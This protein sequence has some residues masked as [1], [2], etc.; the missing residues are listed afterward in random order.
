MLTNTD[1]KKAIT[2][3]QHLE[4]DIYLA[5]VVDNKGVT[6]LSLCRMTI[7]RDDGQET[8]TITVQAARDNGLRP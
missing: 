2:Q 5:P 3:A 6:S 7:Q 4:H 1:A 8:F